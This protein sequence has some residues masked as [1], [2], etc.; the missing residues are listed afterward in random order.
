MSEFLILSS[1]NDNVINQIIELLISSFAVLIRLRV[2]SFSFKNEKRRNRRCV[3]K[4]H[5]IYS[6]NRI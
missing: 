4:H 3:L 6:N 5:I 2:A 1:C